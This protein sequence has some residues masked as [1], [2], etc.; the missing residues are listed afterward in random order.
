VFSCARGSLPGAG[1][2]RSGR[3]NVVE[4]PLPL[5]GSAR[6]TEAD[7][8]PATALTFSVT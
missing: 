7:S 6:T 2:S 3:T 4:P 8:T 5:K 1:G